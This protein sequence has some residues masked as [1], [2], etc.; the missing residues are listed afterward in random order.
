MRSTRAI[1]AALLATA[2]FTALPVLAQQPTTTPAKAERGRAQFDRIDTNK[3]GFI[4]RQEA[5]AARE[6]MFDR[7][8][9]N[10]DGRITREEIAAG[11]RQGPKG[12]SGGINAQ[13]TDAQRPAGA[14]QARAARL[15]RMFQKLD[16][17]KDGGISRAEWNVTV[18][19]RFDRC[20]VN[21]DDKLAPGECRQAQAGRGGRP[22]AP[23]Q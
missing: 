13:P 6:T 17:D 18:D 3:D 5:R 4:D 14:A 20:D 11:R 8:D 15:D 16:A 23:K 10:K 19:A 7:L 1:A 12:Q 9:A 22:A 2:A 21:K